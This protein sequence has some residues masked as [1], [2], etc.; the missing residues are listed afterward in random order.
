VIRLCHV[1]HAA[2]EAC[3]CN[4]APWHNRGRFTRGWGQAVARCDTGWQASVL[5][6]GDA[7][8]FQAIGI[9]HSGKGDISAN[10]HAYLAEACATEKS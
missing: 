10:K 8:L 2:V 3:A 4:G 9:G 6:T 5:V 7:P 1:R